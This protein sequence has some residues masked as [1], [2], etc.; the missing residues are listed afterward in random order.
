L[1]KRSVNLPICILNYSRN[2][3]LTAET[4]AEATG[5]PLFVVSVAEIGLD[6]SKAE[7]NLEQMFYL[8]GKWEAVLL[9]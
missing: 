4:I 7:R 2:T 6:A 5:K 1:E 3:Q 8:A 9:V